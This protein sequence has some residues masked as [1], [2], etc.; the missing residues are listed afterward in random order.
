MD[1]TPSSLPKLA[2]LLE[3]LAA[4]DAVAEGGHCWA[5]GKGL[6]TLLG[7]AASSRAV[8]RGALLER[9]ISPPRSL[10]ASCLRKMLSAASMLARP[11]AR[12]DATCWKPGEGTCSCRSTRAAGSRGS[13][14]RALP[15]DMLLSCP[16]A[17]Q[18]HS[19]QDSVCRSNS[20]QF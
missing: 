5:P 18:T 20:N 4:E 3:L 12:R 6:P 14:G 17:A 13:P 9:W 15:A 10:S 1:G 19:H 11:V 8:A 7:S 2:R 16:G